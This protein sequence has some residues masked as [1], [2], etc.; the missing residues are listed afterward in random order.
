MNALVVL[1]LD[2]EAL[3]EADARHDEQAGPALDGV[4]LSIKETFDVGGLETTLGLPGLALGNGAQLVERRLHDRG[5]ARGGENGTRK[6]GPRECRH[7]RARLVT[8]CYLAFGAAVNHTRSS[9]QVPPCN[10]L[11]LGAKSGLPP[12]SCRSW[13]SSV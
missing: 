9:R 5:T 4:P 11:L 1:R 13:P 2:E 8:H 7:A 3:A 10:S 12:G 6:A